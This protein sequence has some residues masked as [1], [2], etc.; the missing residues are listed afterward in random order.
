[1][2]LALSKMRYKDSLIPLAV[3]ECQL[4]MSQFSRL[5]IYLIKS[6][7]GDN[8]YVRIRPWVVEHIPAGVSPNGMLQTIY[9]RQRYQ[10][11]SP[12]PIWGV[13]IPEIIYKVDGSRLKFVG[14]GIRRDAYFG[15]KADFMERLVQ[16]NMLTG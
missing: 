2:L 11:Q 15:H 14:I 6:S 10:M 16:S 12:K 13:I 7:E 3:L 4:G 5:G 8:R 9:I 1:M